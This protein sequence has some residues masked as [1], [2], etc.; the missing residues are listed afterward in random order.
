[1]KQLDHFLQ[2]LH[3]KVTSKSDEKLL[4]NEETIVTRPNVSVRIHDSCQYITD[5]YD[6]KLNLD[7][8]ADIACLSPEAFCRE[9]KKETRMTFLDFLLRVR[10][11]KACELMLANKNT[12]LSDIAYSCGFGSVSSFNRAFRK[13]MGETPTEYVDH[14][15]SRP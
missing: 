9:F 13:L 2:F 10:I 4:T 7:S 14:Y 8:V 11:V 15:Y 1:M 6:K 3:E 5:N 12:K